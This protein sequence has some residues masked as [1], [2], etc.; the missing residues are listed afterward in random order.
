MGTEVR[1]RQNSTSL[2]YDLPTSMVTRALRGAKSSTPSASQSDRVILKLPEM[3]LT[4]A[5]LRPALPRSATNIT[6]E[7][8][9]PSR[10]G[11]ERGP[12]RLPERAARRAVEVLW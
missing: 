10:L 12:R 1:G 7:L 5:F 6:V 3:L 8:S 9:N 11:Q 4:G 2:V